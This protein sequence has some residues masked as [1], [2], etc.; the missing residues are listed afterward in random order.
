MFARGGLQSKTAD[1][2][3]RK[4]ALGYKNCTWK[5]E[6]PCSLCKVTQSNV[7]G[8]VGGE[9]GDRNYD[10]VSNRRTRGQTEEG[11]RELRALGPGSKAA[12]ALSKKLGIV[13]PDQLN[14]PRALYDLCSLHSLMLACSSELLHLNQLVRLLLE[15]GSA[16][17]APDWIHL[18][19]PQLKQ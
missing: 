13:E 4:G 12:V 10:I 1:T 2:P 6:C 5:T 19:P 14:Q 7:P 15:G 17:K 18:I 9:L 16:K 8:E 11:R 3:Q